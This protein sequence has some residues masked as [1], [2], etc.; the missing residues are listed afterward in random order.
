MSATT[1][2]KRAA[3]RGLDAEIFYPG[4]T[5][6][7]TRPRPRRSAPSARSA[8][9]ASSMPW[10]TA[11][12]RASGAA[13]PSGSAAGSSASVASRPEPPPAAPRRGPAEGRAVAFARGLRAGPRTRGAPATASAG[14]PTTRSSRGP[15]R[16][17]SPASTRPDL[18]EAFRDAGL[19][20]LCIP[21]SLG[22]LGRGDPRAHDRHRGGGQVLQHGRPHA[23]ADP[24]ADRPGPHRRQRRA[25]AAVP[26]GH[27]RRDDA[28]RPSACPSPR[29]GATSWACAPGPCPTPTGTAV[30]CSP[31]A[32]AGCRACAEADWYTVFAKTAEPTSRA[33]DSITAFIVERGWDGRL[34]RPAATTRW[35]SAASTPASCCSTTSGS[36]RRT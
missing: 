30:G 34:G 26:A 16:S 8:R 14:W 4:P 35:A 22:R 36:R 13:R 20:G 24:A 21:E 2:R 5:T 9:H 33:H 27:R 17:T 32:S 11:S 18:F 19:L 1:W 28:G 23:A 25:E 6:R 10:P 3:C 7:P 29:P 12:A 31:G 15:A